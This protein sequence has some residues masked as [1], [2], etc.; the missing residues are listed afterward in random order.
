MI[1]GLLRKAL[2]PIVGKRKAAVI[3]EVVDHGAKKVI[4]R[5]TGGAASK[6]DD[7]L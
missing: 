3:A 2:K 4:D 6:L 5:K 1:R 7:V